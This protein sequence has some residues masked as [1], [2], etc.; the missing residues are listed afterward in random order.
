MAKRW[1]IATPDPDRAE[2]LQRS[3]GVPPIVARLLVA[4]GIYSPDEAQQFLDPKLSGLRD[5]EEL[6][7]VTAAADLLHRAITDKQPIVVYGDYD[8]DGMTSTAIMV[9]CLRLTGAPVSFYV[10]HRLEEGYG[11]NVEA[12]QRLAADG[13]KVVVTVDNGIASLV[14]ADA[15]RELGLTLIVTDHHQMAD[16]LPD[17]AAIVH[18]ALPGHDYPFAGLCGAAVAFKLAWAV[19]QRVSDAK[20]VSEPMR[21]F[22]LQAVGLAAIGTVADVV[23]LVD[24]NRILVRYGLGALRQHQLPGIAE[25][26]RVAKSADKPALGGEDI[27]F[28]LAPRL[29]AA[30]RMGQADLAVELLT[31]D[32]K[33]RAHELADYLDELN[34]TR[35][36]LE[37]SVLLSARKQAKK[38][39]TGKSTPALVLADRDWHPGIIGIVAGKLAEQ[40][41]LPVVMIALD[42]LGTKPGIGSGR[43]APGF[44][45]G[46]AFAACRQHLASCGGHAAAAGLKIE[47]QN[48]DAFRIDFCAHAEA[49][50]GGAERVGEVLIDAEA[51]L[52]ALTHQTVSQIEQ[53]APFGQGNARPTLCTSDVR[54]A[55]PPRRMGGAGRHLSLELEQAGV[56]LR[57]VAFGAGDREE[58]LLRIDGLLSIAFRPVINT[59]RGWA[60]VEMHL[61]DWRAQETPAAGSPNA[62][63][64]NAAMPAA[65]MPAAEMP[66]TEAGDSQTQ[67]SFLSS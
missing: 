15:A 52:S 47:E 54:L 4:R 19:C 39:L 3:A 49:Q 36:S 18:P 17:A 61:E 59:F 29:N 51:P 28:S 8:A 16:R 42:K 6:P 46:E 45:L 55:G 22:L 10:P 30:G 32:S 40:Y 27:G 21:R 23:P 35:Q 64:P 20:R 57:A 25:L 44:N 11:M 50:L 43:T 48:L 67:D 5:P 56:K 58:E 24:E 53:L 9:R 26:E 65:E 13:A 31:T 7:G 63:P 14:E 60:K 38:Y 37:R 62:E 34:Q 41:C 66:A 12:L 1:R 33:E 2:A